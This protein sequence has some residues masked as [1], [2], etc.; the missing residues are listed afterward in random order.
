MSLELTNDYELFDGQ[1]TVELWQPEATAAITV[2]GALRG[3]IARQEAVPAGG[4]VV[5]A[6][7]VWNLPV[8]ELAERPRLGSLIVESSGAAWT[9]LTV[10]LQ[11]LATRWR[12][13]TRQLVIEGAD[14]EV[15]LQRPTWEPDAAG[16]PSASYT[17]YASAVTARVTVLDEQAQRQQDEQLGVA[18]MRVYLGLRLTVQVDDRVLYAGHVL[19]VIRVTGLDRIDRLPELDVE[20]VR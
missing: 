19:R 4:Q 5:Q 20:V 3:P 10:D 9:V 17:T 12:C 1:A 7:A 2:A 8:A 15:D 13:T 18:T 6:D 11:T 14:I 16:A